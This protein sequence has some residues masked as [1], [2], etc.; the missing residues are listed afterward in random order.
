V[1]NWGPEV[2][3]RLEALHVPPSRVESVLD[4][5]SQHLDDRVAEL[6][7]SGQAEEQACRAA[8]AELSDD[9]LRHGGWADL[10]APTTPEPPPGLPAAGLMDGLLGDLRYAARAL[11]RRPLFAITSAL[12]LALG[13]GATS[14]IFGA[15]DAVLLRPMPFPHADRLFVPV[16]DNPGR[17]TMNA[18][19]TFADYEE[20]RREDHLFAR[21]A[22]WVAGAGDLSGGGDPERVRVAAVTEEFFDLIDVAPVVGRGLV[23]ADHAPGAPLVTVIAHGVWQQRFGASPTA[24]GQHLRLDGVSREVVGVLPRRGAWPDDAALF[25]PIVTAD[26]D[27]DVRTRRDNMLFGGLV[28]LQPGVDAATARAR[29]A[30]IAARL[31]REQPEIRKGWTNSLVP[32]R[33]YIV[34]PALARSLYGLFGSVAG[35]LL[36][37]CLN[38]ANLALVRG[39]GR[40]RELA[41]RL[42]LGASRRRLVQQLVV[43]GLV[44]AC[45]GTLAG[46]GLA[47][48]ITR[49][50]VAIAPAGTPFVE[51]IGVDGRVLLAALAA[52]LLAATLSG[53]VPALSTSAVHLGRA[54]REGSAGAGTSR[55]TARTR[56]ALVVAQVAAAVVLVSGSALLVRSFQRLSRVDPGVALD[57]VISGRISI[58]PSRYPSAARREQF[59]QD[60]VQRLEMAPGVESAALTSY[61]PAG[62]GGFALGRVFLP[63]GRPEP[64]VGAD[65]LALWNTVTPR[66]F[67]T[68]GIRLVEGRSFD[69]RDTAGATP[70][71]IVSRLF[72]R[73][74]FGEASPLGKR[75]RAWRTDAVLREIVGVADDVR[76]RGLAEP[77]IPL[78]YVPHAQDSQF[79][80]MMVV[81]RGRGGDPGALAPTVRS[82]VNI[83]DGE[84]AVAD[85]RTLAASARRS[86]AT[87]RY[88]T[89]LL[90]LLAAAAL[91]LAALGIHGVTS[92]V[93]ALRRREMAIRL[94]LGAT[95]R[96]LYALVFRHGFR[97]T[98]LG[99]GLGLAGAVAVAPWLRSLLFDTAPTDPAAWAA[100]FGVLTVSSLVACL[101]PARRAAAEDPT[102]ALRGE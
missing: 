3:R 55:R 43:E 21:V 59:A 41:L 51:D 36:I 31:E 24:V 69:D 100:M 64:P 49:G 89:L 15:V 44:I 80:F 26:L 33:E 27:E 10:P 19:V 74:M 50:L 85:L 61:V 95:R 52:G 28:R 12:A 2:R 11:A 86:I 39:A 17:A 54:L 7:R 76:Y 6:M 75:V 78:V 94:S 30:T 81:A 25:V 37:A 58:P 82:A 14:A 57:R 35:V 29:L 102:S 9:E 18:A 13:I 84:L 88:T 79:Q 101:L 60:L 98:L 4:E 20:W 87:Q 71:M 32:L 70:V 42:A 23:P 53:V 97:L 34:D 48:L 67:A 8:L 68:M 92:Y 1:R 16:S 77:H 83:V 46:I 22:L 40:A 99:L 90:G 66:Y 65:Q 96:D 5:L 38:V 56:H 91:A 73:Q 63:E 47:V 45:A 62:G 93:F 72:A